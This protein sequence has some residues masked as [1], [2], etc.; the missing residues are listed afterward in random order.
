MVFSASRYYATERL[1]S[2]A[3]CGALCGA[4]V[5]HVGLLTGLRCCSF[6]LSSSG[7]SS[8]FGHVSGLTGMDNTFSSTR[9]RLKG[10]FCGAR[11]Q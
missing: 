1:V 6:G 8:N 10:C 5:R 7:P 11:G 2:T 9:W 4:E 3:P